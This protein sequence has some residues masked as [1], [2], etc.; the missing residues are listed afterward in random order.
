M[1]RRRSACFSLNGSD[2]LYEAA[3]NGGSPQAISVSPCWSLLMFW[4]PA[5][6]TTLML[7]LGSFDLINSTKPPACAYQPPPTWPAVHVRFFCC[8]HTAAEPSASTRVT[9]ATVRRRIRPPPRG[10]SVGS[11]PST[12]ARPPR[13]RGPGRRGRESRRR[14][15]GPAG[16]RRRR[17]GAAARRARS[18]R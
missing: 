11:T 13:R 10:V 6:G 4:M 5:P 15:T 2:P 3:M 18:P 9:I 1:T 17:R 12:V 7:K 16:A 14:R 8:A